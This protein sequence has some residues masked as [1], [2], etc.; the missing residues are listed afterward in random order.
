MGKRRKI[1]RGRERTQPTLFSKP[2]YNKED[3]LEKLYNLIRTGVRV[4]KGKEE[5]LSNSEISN[6]K[7]SIANLENKIK[8]E[9]LEK[10]HTNELTSSC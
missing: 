3:S 2:A 6:L 4:K 10:T 9:S 5:T 8:L 7:V 1:K